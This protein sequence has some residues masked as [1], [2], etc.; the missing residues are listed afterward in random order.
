MSLIGDK[1]PWDGCHRKPLGLVRKLG[2]KERISYSVK[3]EGE[4]CPPPLAH[5]GE[6][7][8]GQENAPHSRLG[9]SDRLG[10]DWEH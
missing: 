4:A 3:R 10:Q 7:V 8:D 5:L 1:L 2:G 9:C 6:R